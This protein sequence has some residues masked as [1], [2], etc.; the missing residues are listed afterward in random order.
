MGKELFLKELLLGNKEL[1]IYYNSV[2]R[3][4]GPWEA[5]G[6]TPKSNVRQQLSESCAKNDILLGVKQVKVGL[7]QTDKA[8]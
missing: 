7:K 5:E 6:R 2:C 4:K 3:P 8:L 1:K